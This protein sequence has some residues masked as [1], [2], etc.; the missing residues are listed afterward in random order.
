MSAS[1][2]YRAAVLNHA[3]LTYDG[4]SAWLDGAAPRAAAVRQRAGRWSASCACTTRSPAQLRQWRQQRGALNVKTVPARPV[5]EDGRLVD[6]RADEKNRAK[7]LIADLMI[8]A[9]GATARFLARARL[10]VAAPLPAV[11]AALGPHRGAGGAARRAA[12]RGARS[13]WR[14]TASCAR[15]A[16]ADPAGF[17]DLSLAV[18]KMLGSGEYAAAPA[19]ARGARVTSA[20][21]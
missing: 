2:I 21:R 1:E 9:N 5:F 10:P 8:A 18:V 19:G 4:V 20:W 3:K 13:R 16:P 11:A 7:D 17:A 6:L 14:S 12:A 15:A